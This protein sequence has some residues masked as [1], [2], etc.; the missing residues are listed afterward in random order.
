MEYLWFNR[1]GTNGSVKIGDQSWSQNCASL[2]DAPGPS[3]CPTFYFVQLIPRPPV[4]NDGVSDVGDAVCF[5]DSMALLELDLRAGCSAFVDGQTTLQMTCA[6]AYSTDLF[7][8]TWEQLMIQATGFKWMAP[9]AT[10]TTDALSAGDV[11]PDSVAP[12]QG[13]PFGFG[14]LPSVYMTAEVF[15]WYASAIDLLDTFRVMVP[16][17][18]QFKQDTGSNNVVCVSYNAAGQVAPPNAFHLGTAGYYAL[19]AQGVFPTPPLTSFGTFVDA[20]N[21]TSQL[22]WGLATAYSLPHAGA[23]EVN[24][25][26][27][28][29]SYRWSPENADF[30]LALCT[31]SGALSSNPAVF[32][33]MVTTI[34][35]FP[36]KPV[37]SGAHNGTQVNAGGGGS[38]DVWSTGNNSDNG[39]AGSAIRW[40]TGVLT[41]TTGVCQR[42]S[43][44]TIPVPAL[45]GGYT[46]SARNNDAGTDITNSG[47]PVGIN[48]LTVTATTTPSITVQLV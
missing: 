12:Y 1:T 47:G 9:T 33:Q 15:N 8:F 22:S 40:G 27:A 20:S 38:D 17:T 14:P 21:G 7:D 13:R 35:W 10:Q 31:F 23:W 11:R 32:G 29:A 45:P 44:G 43:S 18:L 2:L 25:A 30:D 5:H 34:Q 41:V 24:P 46:F 48:A 4:D 6:N 16:A 42:F 19:Y 26:V 28:V 36:D 37:V 39:G 3:I